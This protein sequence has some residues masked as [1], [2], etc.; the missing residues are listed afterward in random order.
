MGN[1]NPSPNAGNVNPSEASENQDRMIDIYFGVFF[2]AKDMSLLA[3]HFNRE[4]YM[5]KGEETVSD[6]KNSSIYKTVDEVAMWAEFAT[7]VLPDN[8]VSKAVNTGLN[9]K[10]TVEKTVDD[11]FGKVNAINDAISDKASKIPT[12][13]GTGTE[14]NKS[15]GDA[16]E[17]LIGSRSIISK[18]EPNYVGGE[19]AQEKIEEDYGIKVSYTK[20][21]PSYSFR[22][23]TIGAVTNQEVKKPEEEPQL[24]E[25]T[26]KGFAEKAIEAA[27]N[28]VNQNINPY[29]NAKLSLHFDVFGYAKDPAVKNFI[30]EIDKF[31]QNPNVNEVSVDYEGK[32][33]KFCDAKEVKNSL[34]GTSARFRNLNN[35]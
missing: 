30:S 33:E 32:Y 19:P 26:R 5:R 13:F 27:V 24:N 20:S 3:Q 8:P 1:T 17:S 10:K 14:G 34:G 11:A 21:G 35:L 25:E 2:D 16:G 12:S 4:E 18:L 15:E 31:K 28:A 22:I 9:A 23:Y 6:V 7:N 29:S